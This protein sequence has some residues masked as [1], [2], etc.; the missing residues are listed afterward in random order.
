MHGIVKFIQDGE[1]IKK[2]LEI[3]EDEVKILRFLAHKFLSTEPSVPVS[4]LLQRLFCGERGE[5]WDGDFLNFD[6][7]D[8]ISGASASSRA[9]AQ[10][11]D[12]RNEKLACGDAKTRSAGGSD[13]A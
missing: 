10:T 13:G 2:T 8:A 6:D 12:A 9:L 5:L 7:A 1:E 3:G 4:E 11:E